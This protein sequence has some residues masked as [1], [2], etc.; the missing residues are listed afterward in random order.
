MRRILMS[1]LLS[2]L[3]VAPVAQ[4]QWAVIDVAGIA[5]ALETTVQTAAVVANTAKEVEAQYNIILNQVKQVEWMIQQAQRIPEGLNLLDTVTLWS[6]QLTG[7]L[8]NA[9]IVSYNIDTV[10]GQFNH[11]YAELGTL[12]NADDVLALRQ[13]LLAGRME[14]SQ[15]TVQVTA[16]KQ[17]LTELYTRICA[18][19]SGSWTAHGALDSAQIAHQQN[20]LMQY[21]L[22]TIAT[23]QAAHARNTAQYQAEQAA[24]ERLQLQAIEGAMRDDTPAFTPQGKLPRFAW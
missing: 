23:M 9:N 14:A 12:T 10:M 11:L 13:R 15:M 7:L 18:L 19:L 17:H 3:I 4:A 20:G 22:E 6:N 5:Q 8:G 16:I 24:I 21:T 2:V 1:S